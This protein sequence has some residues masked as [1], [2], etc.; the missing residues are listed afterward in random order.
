M[1]FGIH[2]GPRTSRLGYQG[3]RNEST[4]E[5]LNLLREM[6]KSNRDTEAKGKTET[7]RVWREMES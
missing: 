2:G 3:T 5:G 1:D 7:E 4:Y 6:S